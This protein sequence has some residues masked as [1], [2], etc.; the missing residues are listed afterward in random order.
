MI[1]VTSNISVIIKAKLEQ[2][3]ELKNNPDP[4]LRTIA[5]AVLPELQ[6]TVFM[7]RER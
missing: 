4:V 6:T 1:S 3:R 7:L 5:L 2:I